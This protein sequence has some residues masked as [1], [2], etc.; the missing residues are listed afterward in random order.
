MFQNKS[1]AQ[2][3]LCN[4]LVGFLSRA[5]DTLDLYRKVFNT[6]KYSVVCSRQSENMLE[7]EEKWRREKQT[8]IFVRTADMNP[9]NGW[10]NVR[11]AMSGIRSWKK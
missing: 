5:F 6:E 1:F 3:F 9:Q 2:S 11:D 10:D 7:K 4:L 8:Y